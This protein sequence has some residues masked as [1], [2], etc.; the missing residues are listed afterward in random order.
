MEIN[1]S[2]SE[3]ALGIRGGVT[4]SKSVQPEKVWELLL[5]SSSYSSLRRQALEFSPNKKFIQVEFG[6]LLLPKIIASK[7]A[8]D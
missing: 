8:R 1:L 2:S 7:T 3:S 6:L 4:P 5:G